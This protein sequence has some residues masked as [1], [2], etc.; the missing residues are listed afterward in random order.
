MDKT[1]G[2]VREIDKLGRVVI[3]KDLRVQYGMEDGK[4][5][6]LATR[7]G[8]VIKPYIDNTQTN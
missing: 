2:F 3:P 6:I 1:F 7:E 4:I 8:I 5:V